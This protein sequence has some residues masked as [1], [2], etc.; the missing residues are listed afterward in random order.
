MSSNPFAPTPVLRPR[1]PVAERLLPYLRRIDENRIYANFGPLALELAERLA[2]RLSLRAENIVTAASGSAALI[3]AILGTVGKAR[4]ERPL[5][6][7]PGFTF[8]ATAAAAESCGYEVVFADVDQNSGLLEPAEALNNPLLERIGLVI[9]VGAFGKGI[10]QSGWMRFREQ[11]AA[12]VVID[13]AACFEAISRAP[14]ELLGEIPVA[15][16][17]HATK[18][19]AS[20]EGGCVATSDAG[21]A[22]DIVRALNFGFYGSRECRS[23]SINGKMS[24]YHAAVGLAEL[25]GWSEKSRALMAVADHYRKRF[26]EAGLLERFLGAPE[27]A[28]CYALFRCK[29]GREGESLS[30]YLEASGIGGR[31]WYGGGVHREPYFA[32]GP[33]LPVVEETASTLLGL[34]VAPDLAP[35]KIDQ[36]VSLVASFVAAA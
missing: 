18:S 27:T 11:C 31:F 26:G 17:F 6:L 30:E 19:F 34:P 4:P 10:A 35:K 25:D 7:V 33:A 28:S 12:G 15:L 13:G 16:S 24:E 20:G 21:A 3:G 8:V 23:A 1:L 5:A 36:I 22:R 2:A 29:S 9:P 32:P 14:G